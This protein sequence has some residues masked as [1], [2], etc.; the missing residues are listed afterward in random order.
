MIYY[1]RH[2][3]HNYDDDTAVNIMKHIAE[4]MADD[5]RLLVAEYVMSNPPS[6]FSIW[7]DF[8]MMMSGGKERTAALWKEVGSRAGL[9]LVAF[10]GLQASSDG[11]AVIEF[12]KRR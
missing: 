5:S 4:A 7:M 10:H 9:E 3:L 2:C 11:H 6:R 8:I 12:V 1:I